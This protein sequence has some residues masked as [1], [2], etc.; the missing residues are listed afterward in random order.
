MK[1]VPTEKEVRRFFQEHSYVTMEND[2]ETGGVKI[3]SGDK[4]GLI[5]PTTTDGES[6]E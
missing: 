4:T 2:K 5:Y 6:N 1:P 3:Q